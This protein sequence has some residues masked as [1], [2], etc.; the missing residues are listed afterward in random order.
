MRKS[1]FLPSSSLCAKVRVP[2]VAL[3]SALACMLVST[4]HGLT[5]IEYNLSGFP[6]DPVPSSA[7]ATNVPGFVSASDIVRGPGFTASGLAN[8]F[9][10]NNFPL[11]GTTLADALNDGRYFQVEIGVNSNGVSFTSLDA[12][13]RKSANSAAFEAQWQYSLDGFA[14]DG[15]VMGTYFGDG[16]TVGDGAAQPTL[17]LTLLSGLQ[18][19]TEGTMVTMRL[20]V[21]GV[22]ASAATS[23]ALGRSSMLDSQGGAFLGNSLQIGVIP[24]PS[25]VALSLGLV[26]LLLVLRRRCGRPSGTLD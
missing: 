10:V 9:S 1:S 19:L 16:I 21:W 15:V 20:F 11:G 26:S 17:D 2:R 8:S 25:T 6:A 24:E 5:N 23:F 14:T 18:D 12:R 7:P 3:T 22:P 4:G 13:L